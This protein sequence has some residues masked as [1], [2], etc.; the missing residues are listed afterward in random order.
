MRKETTMKKLSPAA[1]RQRSK[2]LP[3]EVLGAVVAGD[4]TSPS[5]PQHPPLFRPE[6]GGTEQN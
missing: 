5:P 6:P 1:L 4:S 2:R 3:E